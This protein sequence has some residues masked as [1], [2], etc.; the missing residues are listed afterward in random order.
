MSIDINPKLKKETKIIFDRN[1]SSNK[2]EIEGE[3]IQLLAALC[4]IIHEVSKASGIDE[5]ELLIDLYKAMGR[6]RR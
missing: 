1:D 5:D 6:A 3:I 2:V 4:V